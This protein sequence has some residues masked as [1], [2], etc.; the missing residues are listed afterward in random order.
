MEWIRYAKYDFSNHGK[1]NQS[2]LAP[3]VSLS[4]GA[5]ITDWEQYGRGKGLLLSNKKD[6]IATVSYPNFPFSG[7]QVEVV[8]NFQ[9]KFRHLSLAYGRGSWELYVDNDLKLNLNYKTNDGWRRIVT[10]RIETDRWCV[11]RALIEN[12]GNIYIGLQKLNGPSADNT[13]GAEQLWRMDAPP[14]APYPCTE[15]TFSKNPVAEYE[16]TPD[17]WFGF[18][19]NATV[20]FGI[21]L[22]PYKWLTKQEEDKDLSQVDFS[23]LIEMGELLTK[24]GKDANIDGFTDIKLPPLDAKTRYGW[25]QFRYS[26]KGQSL[27]DNIMKGKATNHEIDSAADHL[28]SVTSQEDKIKLLKLLEKATQGK[29]RQAFFNAL[30]SV[31]P[32]IR[33]I[34]K[35]LKRSF[36]H[37]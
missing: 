15:I 27:F 1:E 30:E 6:A 14:G 35:S 24:E 26:K 10:D 3:A 32:V 7:V 23:K 37:D 20:D 16:R 5:E 25:R 22:K 34:R 2:G 8:F 13:A 9:E 17:D 31:H 28:A 11:A 29:H 36:S 18:I 21:S 19:G 4:G 12:N 33:S